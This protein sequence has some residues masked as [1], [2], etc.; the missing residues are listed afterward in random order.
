[1]LTINLVKF[2]DT[3]QVCANLSTTGLHQVHVIEIGL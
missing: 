3:N 2:V 1:M